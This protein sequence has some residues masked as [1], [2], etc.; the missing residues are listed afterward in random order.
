MLSPAR[1]SGE[2]V[3]AGRSQHQPE[4]AAARC[5][6]LIVTTRIGAVVS[7]VAGLREPG[8]RRGAGHRDGLV[9]AARDRHGPASIADLDGLVDLT[10]V[11]VSGVPEVPLRIGFPHGDHGR[12]GPIQVPDDV[13]KGKGAFSDIV[14]GSQ[15]RSRRTSATS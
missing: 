3:P 12:R 8:E 1:R 6:W 7:A 15:A 4:S 14:F 2:R 9:R 10:A 11:V 13:V 5:A